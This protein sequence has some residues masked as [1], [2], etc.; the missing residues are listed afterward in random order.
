MHK[1]SKLQYS[2]S[3]S[4]RIRVLCSRR[5]SDRL[6]SDSAPKSVH[7]TDSLHKKCSQAITHVRS[8]WLAKHN[9]QYSESLSSRIRVL[10]SRRRSDRLS[11]DSAPKF[12]HEADNLH[13]IC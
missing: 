8:Q 9:L 4:S 11:G 5:R 7:E 2:E 3:L 10:Y 1:R 6:S 13:K 12:V